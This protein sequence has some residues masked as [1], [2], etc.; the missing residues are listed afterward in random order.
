[1]NEY[2]PGLTQVL[3]SPATRLVAEEPKA[4]RPPSALI[5]G[6]KVMPVPLG[7]VL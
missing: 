1:M 5:A 7:R 2:A 6:P 3:V 4:T